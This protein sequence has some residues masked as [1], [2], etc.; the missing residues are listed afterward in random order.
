MRITSK[1]SVAVGAIVAAWSVNT[2]FT[3]RLGEESE[4]QIMETRDVLFPVAQTSQQIT[5]RFSEVLKAFEDAAM[6]G[7]EESFDSAKDRLDDVN[8]GITKILAHQ[9]LPEGIRSQ[10]LV[11]NT[12]LAETVPKSLTVYGN[13]TSGGEAPDIEVLLDL[14]IVNRELHE[15]LIA[16]N[17]SVAAMLRQQL[18]RVAESSKEQR[19]TSLSIFLI[20]SAILIPVI[21]YMMRRYISGPLRALVDGFESLSK[22]SSNLSQRL[23]ASG[24][25]EMAEVANWFNRFAGV[26]ERHADE[27]QHQT[28][29]AIASEQRAESALLELKRAES[30]LIQAEKMSSLGELVAGVAH[31]IN[32]PLNFLRS[33]Y[34]AV[35]ASVNKIKDSLF[36]LLPEDPEYG[37]IRLAFED[38]FKKVFESSDNHDMGIDR[39]A[40][41]VTSLRSFSR[42]DE[43]DFKPVYIEEILGDTLV[44]LQNKLKEVEVVREFGTEVRIECQPSKL[45]QVFLNIITNAAY[46]SLENHPEEGAKII[47]TTTLDE[48][49]AVVEIS[50]NG[51]GVDEGVVDTLFDPF[52]TTKPV[53][54][55]TGLGLSVT[56]DIVQQ[57]EGE[58]SVRNDG[59]AVFTVKLPLF[60]IQPEEAVS[61]ET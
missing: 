27:L 40:S 61:Y 54:E 14:A 30:Q 12:R 23:D 45:G 25:D 46:A 19:Q 17:T 28:E 6:L 11:I 39:V 1:V 18:N 53:G 48:E 10:L 32:N 22:S 44:I 58:I 16:F 33:N 41:I 8:K 21:I 24:S 31:E 51:T 43:A 29:Q 38:E 37:E 7:D 36:D 34:L 15:S 60:R 5:F 26:V 13:L 20:T 9:A 4:G 49:Y 2:Y 56:Y 35:K 3:D 42:H 50:D 59:G 47:I 57:H 52:V 55:G